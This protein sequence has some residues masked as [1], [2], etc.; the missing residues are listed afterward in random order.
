MRIAATGA[1]DA[2]HKADVQHVT[3][4]TAR[5]TDGLRVGGRSEG[6]ACE[7]LLATV[8]G[9]GAWV[10]RSCSE[11]DSLRCWRPELRPRMGSGPRRRSSPR[12]RRAGPPGIACSSTRA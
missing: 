3:D 10:Q 2:T 4:K 1:R 7:L 6:S 11:W 12:G 9:Y 5:E 8:A